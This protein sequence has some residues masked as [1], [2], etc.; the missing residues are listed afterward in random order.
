MKQHFI[1]QAEY[2]RWASAELFKSLD[3]LTEEQRRAHLGLFFHDIHR[4]VDHVL[5]ATRNWRARLQGAFE[6][7]APYDAMLCADWNELKAAVLQEFGELRAWL[8][9]QNPEWFQN[10]IEYPGPNG[11]VRRIR[12]HDALMQVMMHAVHHRGQVSAAC[13]RLGAPCPEMDFVFYVRRE[14]AALALD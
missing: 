14:R 4:T 1:E 5:A 11:A 9:A 13:T 7:I 6:R 10:V 2:Q 8:S 3:S 12:V